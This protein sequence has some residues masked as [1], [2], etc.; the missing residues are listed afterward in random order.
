MFCVPVFSTDEEEAI[1][2]LK[3][4]Q[5]PWS[6][7]VQ[8]QALS[9]LPVI[10]CQFFQ[11]RLKQIITTITWYIKFSF[12]PLLPSMPMSNVDSF[13]PIILFFI[14]N[15]LLI[16]LQYLG[17]LLFSHY[18]SSCILGM[19]H[20]IHVSR[21]LHKFGGKAQSSLL[22]ECNYLNKG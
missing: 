20:Q 13:R 4:D 5:I 22:G 7:I 1:H 8:C 18:L 3:E 11:S 14:Q 17:L 9:P 10:H 15:V 6:G 2:I 16:S 12:L 19:L 21:K